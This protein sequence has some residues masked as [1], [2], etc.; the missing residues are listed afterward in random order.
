MAVNT[1]WTKM[2]PYYC[3]LLLLCIA[4][5]KLSNHAA[6]VI[7]EH[8][9]IDERTC[10]AIDA[11]HGGIDGGAVS[12][13][14]IRESQ[15]NLEIA[16]RLD[17]LLHLLGYRTLMLRTT[18]TSLHTDGDT[19]SAQKISD[20]KQRVKKVAESDTSLLISIHQNTFSDSRYS[21]AQVFYHYDDES[22]ELAGYL[23]NNLIGTLNPGSNRKPKAAKGIY[24]ME[25]VNCPALLVEC[26]FLTNAEEETRL[27]NPAYQK[28]LSA[29][30]A[31]TVS[32][33]LQS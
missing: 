23:Q 11:G 18:D 9:P 24:L 33:R 13:S 19:I 31:A 30:I 5:V 2:L 7:V 25:H 29:V 3:I 14:G 22:F 17:D 28:Y 8:S 20:L 15:I 10:I 27:R 4:I 21:G 1:L 12:V 16:N 32:A 26:G 6:T